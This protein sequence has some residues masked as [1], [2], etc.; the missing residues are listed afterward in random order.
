LTGRRGRAIQWL[1]TLF[2][3]VHGQTL[4]STRLDSPSIVGTL[5]NDSVTGEQVAAGNELLLTY[6]GADGHSHLSVVDIDPS[7]LRK[8]TP[9]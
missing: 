7:A 1:N 9:K 2:L 3:M 5:T 8:A 4:V 6:T